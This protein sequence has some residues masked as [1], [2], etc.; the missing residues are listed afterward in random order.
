MLI[1]VTLHQATKPNQTNKN[2]KV[3]SNTLCPPLLHFEYAWF[4]ARY[5][6]LNTSH[7]QSHYFFFF[8]PNVNAFYF[9]TEKW[10]NTLVSEWHALLSFYVV[11]FSVNSCW[12]QIRWTVRHILSSGTYWRCPYFCP[13]QLG[14]RHR[15]TDATSKLFFV[16]Y[17]YIYELLFKVLIIILCT[18]HLLDS[19]WRNAVY[20][21]YV[22]PES[23][24]TQSSHC[25]QCPVFLMSDFFKETRCDLTHS[26]CL[27][28]TPL[29]TMRQLS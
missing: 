16:H 28:D 23:K 13:A 2:I 26:Q 27:S 7:S 29:H 14:C 18:W 20:W 24:N 17:P 3:S 10:T 6:V 8:F 25:Q 4:S 12:V 11:T 5:P 1:V 19:Q 22:H 21:S 15:S 9:Q